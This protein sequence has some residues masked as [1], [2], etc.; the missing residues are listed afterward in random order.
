MCP[1]M[2]KIANTFRSKKLRKIWSTKWGTCKE[3]MRDTAEALTDSFVMNKATIA[4]VQLI[5]SDGSSTHCVSILAYGDN[6]LGLPG[7]RFIV[8]DSNESCAMPLTN[9]VLTLCTSSGK[10]SGWKSILYLTAN[11]KL[12]NSEA[13]KVRSLLDHTMFRT[14]KNMMFSSH[15]EVHVIPTLTSRAPQNWHPFRHPWERPSAQGVDTSPPP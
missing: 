4:M 5:G 9:K 3:G 6:T 12:I 11:K 1:R 15:P 13:R 2:N 10:C 14:S 7:A 8:V